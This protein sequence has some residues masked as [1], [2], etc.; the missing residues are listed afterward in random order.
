MKQQAGRRIKPPTEE[1]E[2][3]EQEDTQNLAQLDIE[4]LLSEHDELLKKIYRK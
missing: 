2:K 3:V 1:Q 4:K